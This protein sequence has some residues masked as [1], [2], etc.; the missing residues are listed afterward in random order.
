MKTFSFHG[1]SEKPIQIDLDQNELTSTSFENGSFTQIH[2][3]TVL[4][5]RSNLIEY[6]NES[7]F[8][9]L[10]KSPSFRLFP[11]GNHIICDCN[12]RWILKEKL[13]TQGQFDDIVCEDG[14]SL[15]TK[16]LNDLKFC[17]LTQ[18]DVKT[19]LSQLIKFFS[20]FKIISKAH[21]K[22]ISSLMR[23]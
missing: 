5:I 4:Y 21:E 7:I 18:E 23:L 10:L 12:N 9:P 15:W 11:L 3:P 16:D 14:Q 13:I 22:Q 6:L 19:G 8:L 20:T 17:D 1:T 2:R